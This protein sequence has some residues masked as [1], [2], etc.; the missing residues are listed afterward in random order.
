MGYMCRMNDESTE[1]I[2]LESLVEQIT[3]ENRHA[4]IETGPAVGKEVW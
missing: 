1:T 2:T 4:E 3:A